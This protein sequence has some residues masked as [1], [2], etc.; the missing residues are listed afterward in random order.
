MHQ[1]LARKQD[2][3][4]EA[5]L[6]AVITALEASDEVNHPSHHAAIRE[7]VL[8]GPLLVNE[9]YRAALKTPDPEVSL[10]RA[11]IVQFL[12]TLVQ[13]SGRTSWGDL[14]TLDTFKFS[15]ALIDGR[16]FC[17]VDTK[18][19]RDLAILHLILRL[20]EVGLR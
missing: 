20:Q 1:M 15:G 16:V 7:L 2:R 8:G 14:C 11:E 10:W 5:K 6:Q 17:T 4:P 13:T 18:T 19:I 9:T 3:S 12:R